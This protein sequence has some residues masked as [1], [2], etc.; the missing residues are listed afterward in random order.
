MQKTVVEYYNRIRSGRPSL[1]QSPSWDRE[2]FK[3]IISEVGES[4]IVLDLGCGSGIL[5]EFLSEYNRY[6]GLDIN[7]EYLRNLHSKKIDVV[8]GTAECLPFTHSVFDSVI[9]AEVLEHVF[10]PKFVLMNIYKV[11]KDSGK[12]IVSIPNIAYWDYRKELLFGRFP[13]N[14]S[15]IYP[16]EHIRFF[17]KD[18]ILWLLRNTGFECIK[19]DIVRNRVP[20]QY[21]LPKFVQ[22][23]LC[24]YFPTL[25]A[26]QF[27]VVAKK[28]I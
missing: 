17:T 18:D 2:R 25:M 3:K 27:I 5:A 26:W 28:S 15:K 10:N 9:C 12:V 19:V 4:C 11:L 23:K 14:K 7:K 22:D 6:V 8:L 20:L 24:H 13:E 1:G 16:P 21:L